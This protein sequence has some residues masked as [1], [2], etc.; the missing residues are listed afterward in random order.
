SMLSL[1]RWLLLQTWLQLG[2][3]VCRLT[4]SGLHR[5]KLRRMRLIGDVPHFK[6]WCAN[7][8]IAVPLRNN[9]VRQCNN[10]SDLCLNHWIV[11]CVDH[12][13]MHSLAQCRVWWCNRNSG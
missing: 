5:L 7:H 10:C 13:S 4:A 6:V 1:E 11:L 2:C 3:V 12:C 8:Y 9:R